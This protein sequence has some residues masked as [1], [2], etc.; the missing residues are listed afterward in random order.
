MWKPWRRKMRRKSE[1]EEARRERIKSEERLAE[2]QPVVVSLHEMREHN[3]I[4]PLLRQLIN[5]QRNPK[6]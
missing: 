6:E 1:V 3:H 4:R 5:E 2:A